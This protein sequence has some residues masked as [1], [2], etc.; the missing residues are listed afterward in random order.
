MTTRSS[1]GFDG[2]SPVFE[3]ETGTRFSLGLAETVSAA[4]NVVQKHFRFRIDMD[5]VDATPS[6][7]AAEDVGQ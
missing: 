2:L 5:A 7:G 6:W 3:N 1:P 4:L